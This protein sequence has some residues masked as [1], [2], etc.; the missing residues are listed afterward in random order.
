MPLWVTMPVATP[1][2]CPLGLSIV[3]A[4]LADQALLDFADIVK[5]E[6]THPAAEE[7]ARLVKESKGRGLRLIAENVETLE[8]FERCIELGFD[9]FQG[10]FLQHPQ[11][12]SAKRVPSS[13]LSTLRLVASRPTLEIQRAEPRYWPWARAVM[14]VPAL[15]ELV[16]WNCVIRARKVTGEE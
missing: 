8:Q 11:T 13:R 12:F 6:I 14:R 4:P 3:G 15:R 9:G 2:A 16:S 7:L 1:G 5:L 10:N